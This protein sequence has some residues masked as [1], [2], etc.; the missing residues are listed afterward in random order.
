MLN[1]TGINTPALDAD[2]DGIVVTGRIQ[3]I[4]SSNPNVFQAPIHIAGGI[5]I[6][7]TGQSVDLNNG[8]VKN[9]QMKPVPDDKDATNVKFVRD[10]MAATLLSSLLSGT[11]PVGTVYTNATN[12]NNPGVSSGP[13]GANYFGTWDEYAEGR[14]I[15]GAGST[16][17][18]RGESINFSVGTIG[19][20]FQHVLTKP[21]MPKH[22]HTGGAIN[23]AGGVAW[24]NS[25]GDK[26]PDSG[27]TSEQGNDQP[28][29]NIQPYIVAKV[30]VRTA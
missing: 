14:V 24:S 5:E 12:P 4:G 30:W 11:Y 20:E 23:A 19:G 7:S 15:I 18:T 6:T 3:Q 13:F 29:N 16:S 1:A 10:Q 17:D 26:V 8:Y 9:L 28:H 25:G 27:L 21:E 22:S 2:N